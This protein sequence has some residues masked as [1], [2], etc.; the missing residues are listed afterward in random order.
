MDLD[1]G[2]EIMDNGTG[3]YH[4]PNVHTSLSSTEVNGKVHSCNISVWALECTLN[5]VNIR[6]LK[7]FLS[8]YSQT[9]E[10]YFK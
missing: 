9:L 6:S 5:P 8:S 10:I 7:I 3:S 4:C 1:Y 2:L